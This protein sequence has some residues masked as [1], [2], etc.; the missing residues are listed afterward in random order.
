MNSRGQVGVETLIAVF[1]VLAL[2]LVVSLLALQNHYSVK[3]LE[4]AYLLDSECYNLA[5]TI[6]FVFSNGD[7]MKAELSIL[8]HAFIHSQGFIAV[9]NVSEPEVYS[10]SLCYFNA[11]VIDSNVS[12]GSILIENV[13]GIVNVSQQ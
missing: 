2:F 7:G 12:T 3:L 5:E 1:A 11:R 6:N 4:Q 9:E 13:G 8:N 10:G